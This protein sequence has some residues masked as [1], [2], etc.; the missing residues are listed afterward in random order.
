[1]KRA[2]W[3]G[4]QVLKVAKV[5][6]IPPLTDLITLVVFGS[7]MSPTGM[8][9]CRLLSRRPTHLINKSYFIQGKPNLQ[10]GKESQ[11][12]Q[13]TGK[14]SASSFSLASEANGKYNT[15]EGH[16]TSLIIMTVACEKMEICLWKFC[17]K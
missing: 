1:M 3:P 6:A 9:L 14:E 5:F 15:S 2:G 11:L 4:P 8:S 12:L 10:W 16:F 7:R 13:R 17:V